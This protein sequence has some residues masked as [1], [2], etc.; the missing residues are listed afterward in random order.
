MAPGSENWT[1]TARQALPR[2]WQVTRRLRPTLHVRDVTALD[3][4]F[5][6]RHEVAALLWDVDGTLMAY[7][8]GRVARELEA[9]LDNLRDK[10]PQAILSNCG[11]ERFGELGAIFEGLPIVKGYRL[12]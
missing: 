9:A 5:L 10:V 12:A 8:D 6:R 1:T 4:E 2:L 3:D 11:E 7:H